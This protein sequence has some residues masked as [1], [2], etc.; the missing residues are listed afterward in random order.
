MKIFDKDTY[1]SSLKRHDDVSLL[2]GHLQLVALAHLPGLVRISALD[3]HFGHDS[4]QH[5]RQGQGGVPSRQVA[6][7][8]QGFR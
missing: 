2:V 1:R 6:G 5:A 4:R 3:T 8:V 7:L